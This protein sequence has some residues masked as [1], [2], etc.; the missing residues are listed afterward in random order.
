MIQVEDVRNF[1]RELTVMRRASQTETTIIITE[2]YATTVTPG[3]SQYNVLM[4]YEVW[5]EGHT[6]EPWQY[7]QLM[8]TIQEADILSGTWFADN[9]DDYFNYPLRRAESMTVSCLNQ[10]LLAS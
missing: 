4:T 2:V 6:D 3:A 9:A 1:T 8:P 10:T 7:G 5:R